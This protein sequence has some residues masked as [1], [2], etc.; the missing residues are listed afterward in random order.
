MPRLTSELK[1]RLEREFAILTAVDERRA[2]GLDI[3]T[4]DQ[5]IVNR[6]L[7]ELE[8]QDADAAIEHIKEQADGK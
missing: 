1:A 8:M 6:H 7:I 2:A 5:Q 3:G 4:I